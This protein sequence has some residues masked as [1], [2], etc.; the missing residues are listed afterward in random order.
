MSEFDIVVEATTHHEGFV[1]AETE[2]E[3]KKKGLDAFRAG[4]LSDSMVENLSVT[5]EPVEGELSVSTRGTQS[6]AGAPEPNVRGIIADDGTYHVY[7]LPDDEDA[8][9]GHKITNDC[10]WPSDFSPVCDGC[11]DH[12]VEG[13]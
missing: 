3:A 8:A 13:D 1:D 12:I 10:E 5:V 9:A 2:E 6:D 4:F 7:C 11:G